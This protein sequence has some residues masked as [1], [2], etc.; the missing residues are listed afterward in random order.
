MG[1][2][3]PPP[4]DLDFAGGA[5]RP[6]LLGWLVLAA[7]LAAALG[8]LHEYDVL[9][10]RVAEEEHRVQRLKRA[11]DRAATRDPALAPPSE[12][13]LRPALRAAQ[14]LLR[15][16]PGLLAHLEL[17]ADDPAI[18][19]LALDLD[20]S[21]GSLKLAG[22]AGS[23]AGVFEFVRRMGQ[24]GGLRDVRLTH[25]DFHAVA[26]VQSVGFTLTAR[27]ESQR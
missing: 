5:R 8:V 3:A 16:W 13:E 11:L 1:R 12:G 4:L 10:G 20:G 26:G 14:G 9:E 18:A 15:D 22:E 27:W 7:G 19:V 17:A 2:R 24:G 25:Y 23:L 21:P 6:S